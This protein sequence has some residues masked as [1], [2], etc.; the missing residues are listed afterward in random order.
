MNGIFY[1]HYYPDKNC[2]CS[3]RLLVI[4]FLRGLFQFKYFYYIKL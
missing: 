1:I 2:K 3:N 4:G